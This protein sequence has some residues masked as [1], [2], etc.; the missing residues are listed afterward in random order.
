MME[1]INPI[2][3]IRCV[4]GDLYTPADYWRTEYFCTKRTPWY[5]RIFGVNKDKYEWVIYKAIY[6][7]PQRHRW[8]ETY[9]TSRAKFNIKVEEYFFDENWIVARKAYVKLYF[10]VEGIMCKYFYYNVERD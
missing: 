1:L 6:G 5:L 2:Q 3:I 7:K 4:I 9:Y 8:F 10:S